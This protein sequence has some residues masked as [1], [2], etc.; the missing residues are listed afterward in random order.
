MTVREVLDAMK[1]NLGSA[2]S[3]ERGYRDNI[4]IGDPDAVVTGIACTWM[5]TIGVIKRAHEAK[6]NFIVN[7][8][9]TWWT[10]RDDT[11][12]LA[13]NKLYKLKAD[14][15][16]QNGIV[17]WR[18]HDGQ[19]ARKPDQSIVALL[20]LLGIEDE[21]AF[22]NS[23]KV[24]EIPET[25]LGEFASAIR[26]RAGARAIRVAGDPKMKVRRILAGPGYASPTIT[27]GVDVVVGGEGQESDGGF[28][29]TSYVLDAAE[30]G[31]PKGQIILGHGVSEEPGMEECAKWLRGFITN[32]PVQ[33]IPAGEPYWT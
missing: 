16:R 17:I 29:N 11:K 28:D 13:E 32:V 25:T 4:K 33:H 3:G 19:H 18:F 2:W 26:K 24:Y 21:N 9:D 31:V 20:R 15:C 8:E 23:G 10:D 7:H 22:M 30:L 27:A 1:K 5:A 12:G 14:Y 6:L